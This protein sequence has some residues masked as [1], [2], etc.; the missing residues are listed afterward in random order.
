M[1]LVLHLIDRG[2]KA[3]NRPIRPQMVMMWNGQN[4]PFDDSTPT[5]NDIGTATQL[6]AS[7]N[8]PHDKPAPIGYESSEP[9]EY[10]IEITGMMDP[11]R[12]P[13]TTHMSTVSSNLANA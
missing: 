4:L 6:Y 7:C 8:T 12:H 13:N 9:Y 10:P 3:K 2:N 5:R 11:P 1:P